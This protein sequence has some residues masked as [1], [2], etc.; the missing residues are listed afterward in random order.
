MLAVQNFQ[1]PQ[2]N[3]GIPYW[4]HDAIKWEKHFGVVYGNVKFDDSQ[5]IEDRFSTA[6]QLDLQR[7][8]DVIERKVGESIG[9]W[10]TMGYFFGSR[11]DRWPMEKMTKTMK[12]KI[13]EKSEETLSHWAE[14]Y[15][16][17]T[18]ELEEFGQPILKKPQPKK[19]I[20]T[21]SQAWFNFQFTHK[22]NILSSIHQD[23]VRRVNS[24]LESEEEDE[25]DS[26]GKNKKSMHDALYV[27][28]M[29]KDFLVE[30][31]KKS[32]EMGSDAVYTRQHLVGS[33]PM[34]GETAVNL[35]REE[36]EESALE[37]FFRI[38]DEIKKESLACRIQL[39]WYIEGEIQ[40]AGSAVQNKIKKQKK[41]MKIPSAISYPGEKRY[42]RQVQK[43][44]REQIVAES[45]QFFSAE[46]SS[47]KE[48]KGYFLLQPL[49]EAWLEKVTNYSYRISQDASLFHG[50]D[51]FIRDAVKIIKKFA[52]TKHFQYRYSVEFEDRNETL[53]SKGHRILSSKKS[54]MVDAL[55]LEL[56][57][58]SR[59]VDASMKELSTH[60][61]A[62]FELLKD[63]VTQLR[64]T[65][66]SNLSKQ[67]EEYHAEL[68][69]LVRT[70]HWLDVVENSC[71]SIEKRVK[72]QL[73]YNNGILIDD[74]EVSDLI[75]AEKMRIYSTLSSYHFAVEPSSSLMRKERV[76]VGTRILLSI[77][78]EKNPAKF[79][80]E[81]SS[82]IRWALQQFQ[83]SK[84]QIIL[85]KEQSKGSHFFVLLEN[86][87]QG[88]ADAANRILQENS[89]G[90]LLQK[91]AEEYIHDVEE[92]LR[93]TTKIEGSVEE[94]RNWFRTRD[95]FF[96]F[97]DFISCFSHDFSL[98]TKKLFP[99]WDQELTDVE[100]ALS[101]GMNSDI[102]PSRELID[103]TH[104]FRHKVTH[105][106]NEWLKKHHD[107]IWI[108]DRYSL[109][110]KMLG[111][112]KNSELDSFATSLLCEAIVEHTPVHFLSSVPNW[113]WEKATVG[114]EIGQHSTSSLGDRISGLANFGATCF[115][116]TIIQSFANT[117]LYDL[118]RPAH[119]LHQYEDE[120]DVQFSFR[121]TMKE[122]LFHLVNLIR[123]GE[124]TEPIL[125][126]VVDLLLELKP[127]G[128]ME[129]KNLMRHRD[130]EE[131]LRPLLSLLEADRLCGFTLEATTTR[132]D[133]FGRKTVHIEKTREW[134]L[135]L[136]IGI[137]PS[138]EKLTLEILLDQY[139]APETLEKV[140]PDSQETVIKST[141][142]TNISPIL[143]VALGRFSTQGDAKLHT[144]QAYKNRASVDL[145]GM[146][147]W[148]WR[149]ML[150]G[151]Q[152]A[153]VHY[154]AGEKL[155]H[156]H[157]T[158]T[159]LQKEKWMEHDDE[160][161]MMPAQG[162]LY[163]DTYIGIFSVLRDVKE[164][165]PVKD[166][167]IPETIPVSLSPM[168]EEEEV[169]VW[170]PT[171]PEPSAPP[172]ESEELELDDV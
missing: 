9:Q 1:C 75:L 18:V 105:Q 59:Q 84:Q 64:D 122:K 143:L 33:I 169:K 152:G 49:G 149:G 147:Y 140:R 74:K 153:A 47:V 94:M 53:V 116:N 48:L 142:I 168:V 102:D 103:L 4:E 44:S 51:D 54:S 37:R 96:A 164:K 126:E 129:M 65:Y 121:L 45:E 109:S 78:K 8:G 114:S 99:L 150:L 128:K 89:T 157:Y 50:K 125:R 41:K 79:I 36:K 93:N 5:T 127:E 161:S 60:A 111:M 2:C 167:K 123:M 66:K 55:L 85:L 71:E 69:T 32:K 19:A 131:Y 80:E 172:M 156:G 30:V 10:E 170:I 144:F 3:K 97:R 158:F 17:K 95:S 106:L 88:N 112:W 141:N 70:Q 23:V 151:L 81:I 52:D 160:I 72:D 90:M 119:V 38:R 107:R 118:L 155:T 134:I 26:D 145:F 117:G 165:Q 11:Y 91:R 62:N 82:K 7:W 83:S 162:N 163:R 25:D 115:L 43:N 68:V 130:V 46:V 137:V 58:S 77:L 76:E 39:E 133:S 101:Y 56:E 35:V 154:D 120:G 29:L 98:S 15:Q 13:R 100:T 24:L 40:R 171:K 42:Y 20:Q 110:D 135:P 61:D 12:E 108:E 57:T 124:S 22:D 63:T 31:N 27:K 21:V 73:R 159:S 14:F 146:N 92:I 67:V 113:I 16:E 132:S 34:P 136:P 28:E 6:L 87:I 86:K 148:R 138:K 166:K 104:V 139:I